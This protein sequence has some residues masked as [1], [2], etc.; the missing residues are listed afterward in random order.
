MSNYKTTIAGALSTLGKTLMGVGVLP[1]LA[2]GSSKVLTYIAIAGFLCDAIGSFL[3]HL[4]SADA[5]TVSDLKQAVTI[6]TESIRT[7]DT[8]QLSKA[9]CLNPPREQNLVTK[10]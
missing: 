4:F 1:Q 8:S 6:N 2:N 7:G 3:G 5:K 10:D 9:D